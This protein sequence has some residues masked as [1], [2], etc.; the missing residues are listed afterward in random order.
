MFRRMSMRKRRK[1]QSHFRRMLLQAWIHWPIVSVRSFPGIS[2]VIKARSSFRCEE[3]CNREKDGN[4]CKSSCRCQNGGICDE[5]TQVCK[6]PPGWTGDVCANRCQPGTFGHSCTQTCECF[7]GASCDH[8]LGEKT[9]EIV[10]VFHIS[11]CSECVVSKC[12]TSRN[13]M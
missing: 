3:K 2:E 10:V 4:E 6:C 1:M 5:D 8:V 11:C 12:H 13:E 9:F 7:N